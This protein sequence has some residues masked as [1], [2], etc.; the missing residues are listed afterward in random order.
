LVSAVSAGIRANLCCKARRARLDYFGLRSS[1]PPH[2]AVKLDGLTQNRLTDGLSQDCPSSLRVEVSVRRPFGLVDCPP[3]VARM[4]LAADN[5]KPQ[6]V[7]WLHT[8][9]AN[10][11]KLPYRG[12]HDIVKLDL[13]A[14][15]ELAPPVCR[16]T[17]NSN[18]AVRAPR[19]TLRA[20]VPENR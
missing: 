13:A 7:S 17:R 6:L 19:P 14:C 18:A 15:I 1:D 10:S 9:N 16:R 8:R 11:T 2:Q 20:A 4:Q 3:F 5:S 12:Y